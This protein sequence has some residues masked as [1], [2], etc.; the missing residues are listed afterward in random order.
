MWIIVGCDVG[1]DGRRRAMAGGTCGVDTL[2]PCAW[3]AHACTTR[4][5]GLFQS[6]VWCASSALSC[7]AALSTALL[8]TDPAGRIAADWQWTARQIGGKYWQ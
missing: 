6:G 2:I 7:V 4:R 1:A 3:L 5:A 8:L